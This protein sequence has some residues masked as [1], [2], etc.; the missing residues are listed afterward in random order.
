MSSKEE[1]LLNFV[2]YYDTLFDFVL[3]L[4]Q[5]WNMNISF[6]LS[7]SIWDVHSR[8]LLNCILSTIVK[9]ISIHLYFSTEL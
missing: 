9:I 5:M 6:S 3:V 7:P 4:L 1:Y 2:L 8:I